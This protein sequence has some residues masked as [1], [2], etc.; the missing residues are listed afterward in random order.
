MVTKG[1]EL[2]MV[3][4]RARG[5]QRPSNSQSQCKLVVGQQHSMENTVSVSGTSFYIG[6]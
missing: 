6:R 5:M 2:G 3:G 4:G 1:E